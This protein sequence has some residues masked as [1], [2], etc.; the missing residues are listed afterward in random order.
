LSDEGRSQW[1]STT[2][3]AAEVDGERGR[4][5]TGS[6]TTTAAAAAAAAAA[7]DD[8]EEEDEQDSGGARGG[9]RGL[10]GDG[11]GGV[12]GVGCGGGVGGGTAVDVT[13]C[14]R[15][16]TARPVRRTRAG[17]TTAWG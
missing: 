15:W 12:G 4:G 6:T 17:R 13:R 5:E 16:R 2:A 1:R 7:D 10:G 3:T 11:G 8:V 14:P 9:H